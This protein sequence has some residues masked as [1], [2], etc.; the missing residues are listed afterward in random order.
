LAT[1]IQIWRDAF[2]LAGMQGAGAPH[3]AHHFVR[4][5]STP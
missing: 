4:M 5:S 1:A 2:L 3:A